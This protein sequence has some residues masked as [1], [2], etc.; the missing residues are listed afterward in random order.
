MSMTTT[1]L[2]LMPKVTPGAAANQNAPECTEYTVGWICALPVEMAA[3]E[4]MLD[5]VFQHPGQ[6]MLDDNI[7]VVGRI[8]HLKM[9]IVCLPY[10]V[11]GTTSAT[12][13]AEQMRQT[14]TALRYTLL[15][16]VG[17][18]MP[19]KEFDVRLGDV[20]VSAPSASSPG[21]VQYDYG[22]DI[23]N[24]RF[25]T[26]GHLNLPPARLLNAIS[27]LESQEVLR[28][29]GTIF[30]M[31]RNIDMLQAKY[32]NSERNWSYPGRDKDLLFNSSYDHEEGYQTC[33][34]CDKAYLEERPQRGSIRP[35]V[36]YG[37]I[38]SANRV[39]RNGAARERLRL[40][41]N[42][43]CV[44][45]EAAGLMNNFACLVIRG[46][47]DYADSHKNKDWQLYAAVTAAAYAKELLSVMP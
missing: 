28:L 26:T 3:A 39:M 45:M 6:G 22:K 25:I 36:H 16:G 5:E 27:R 7:Y 8:A 15:V 29:S 37:T 31:A 20:V 24:D 46:I 19:S 38:A 34:M 41:K 17:G 42:A 43:L 18:G 30:P 44:E 12:R 10:G 35:Q 11:A 4:G 21:V 47:C 9:V 32:A 23:Q 1:H 2:D 33:E 14:F 13:V 40:D